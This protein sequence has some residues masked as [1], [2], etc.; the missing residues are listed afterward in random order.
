MAAKV[1]MKEYG[2]PMK[3]GTKAKQQARNKDMSELI[4]AIM[5]HRN[6]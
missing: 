4:K 3:E 5:M 2:I 1:G 6:P